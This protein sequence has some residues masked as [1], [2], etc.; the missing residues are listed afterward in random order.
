[1]FQLGHTLQSGPYVWVEQCYPPAVQAQTEPSPLH[2][3]PRDPNSRLPQA[4]EARKC[5]PE[6]ELE[7]SRSMQGPER[8]TEG[9]ASRAGGI[10]WG[11]PVVW[12]GIRA[13]TFRNWGVLYCLHLADTGVSTLLQR[14][15]TNQP[16]VTLLATRG[17]L[18]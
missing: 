2:E 6:E 7:T 18:P 16:A 13:H 9:R 3:A 15:R 4:Q 12:A 8:A 17:A 1:M 11:S 5:V 14:L 10:W